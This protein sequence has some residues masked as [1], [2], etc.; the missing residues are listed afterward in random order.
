MPAMLRS[1]NHIS[2]AADS[3]LRLL[4]GDLLHWYASSHCTTYQISG[5][6]PTREGNNQIRFALHHYA[7]VTQPF[8]SRTMRLKVGI[9][10]AG[11]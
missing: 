5:S 2:S 8:G 9:E 3:A 11:W 10:S 6:F 7:L 1:R 4:W